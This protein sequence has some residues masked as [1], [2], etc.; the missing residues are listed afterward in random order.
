[1]ISMLCVCSSPPGNL[2][3][4]VVGL[5]RKVPFFFPFSNSADLFLYRQVLHKEGKE[6]YI[7]STLHDLRNRNCIPDAK[8]MHTKYLFYWFTVLTTCVRE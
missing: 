6:V 4:L 1:M 8:D 3:C 2:D 7:R 5:Q